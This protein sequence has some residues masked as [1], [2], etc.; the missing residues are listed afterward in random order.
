M[1]DV[2]RY[3][4]G[5][6]NV[7]MLQC[8]ICREQAP[9]GSQYITIRSGERTIYAFW[10]TPDSE[11]G[12]KPKHTGGKKPYVMLMTQ[13]IVE[14]RKQGVPNVEELIGFMVCLGRN[15]EWGTGKLVKGRKK[16]PIRYKDLLDMFSCGK[17]KLDRVLKQMQ[18]YGLL[19]NTNE[20]YFVST[21][22]IKKGS[23]K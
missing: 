5:E 1:E 14:L 17:R 8:T 3:L 7:V 18:E 2:F 20:G 13:E 19:S 15:V 16:T 9:N 12:K 10:H 6:T 23:T 4:L 11:K 21:K 22:L